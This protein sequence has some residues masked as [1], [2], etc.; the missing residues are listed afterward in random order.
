MCNIPNCYI[1]L[2]ANIFHTVFIFFY[3]ST[4]D[5]VE[6]N[7]PLLLR[8]CAA[9][10]FIQELIGSYAPGPGVIFL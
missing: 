7:T 4:F 3:V 8:A 9:A 1:K 5:D 6:K 10:E 2:H